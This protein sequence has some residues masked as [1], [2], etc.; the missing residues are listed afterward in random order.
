MN[1]ETPH[2]AFYSHWMRSYLKPA[3]LAV[4]DASAASH[5]VADI[6]LEALIDELKTLDIA[7]AARIAARL[8]AGSSVFVQLDL[9][10]APPRGL[11]SRHC[12]WSCWTEGPFRRRLVV[13]PGDETTVHY[14]R[15]GSNPYQIESGAS[16]R[17]VLDLANWDNSRWSNVP[18]QSKPA[19]GT[20]R[21][22]AVLAGADRK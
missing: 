5:W 7:T 16:F 11:S 20:H 1:N 2:A 10:L 19:P 14:G 13:W 4:R 12:G 8:A 18:D 3:I 17:M 22:V 21:S 6:S 15:S 9:V